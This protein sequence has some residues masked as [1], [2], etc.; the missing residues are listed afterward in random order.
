[1]RPLDLLSWWLQRRSRLAGVP[2]QWVVLWLRQDVYQG[3]QSPV[4]PGA[5]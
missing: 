2:S 3:S 4:V 5:Q 1:M